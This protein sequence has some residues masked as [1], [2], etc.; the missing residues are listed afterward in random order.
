MA[1]HNS[2]RPTVCLP[3]TAPEAVF[4][5]VPCRS[6]K[7]QAMAQEAVRRAGSEGKQ[8]APSDHTAS[9]IR[10]AGGAQVSGPDLGSHPGRSRQEREAGE[11]RRTNE[12][13]LPWKADALA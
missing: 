8:A 12:E 4:H 13:T 7:R 3:G 5:L 2:A 11:S 6:V 10:R 9:L 1:A